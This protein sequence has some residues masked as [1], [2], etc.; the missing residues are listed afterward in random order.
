MKL[1]FGLYR[2]QL[3]TDHFRF[4]RQC[5]ATHVVVHYTDYF[6][7]G[8][9]SGNARGD[10][11]TGD[12]LGWG[13]AGD[14]EKLWTAD[15]LTTLRKN[16]E[17]E[18]LKLWALENFDPAH[19]HDILLD[20]PLRAKHIENVKT[21]IHN[22]GAAGIPVMGYFF[23]IAGVFGRQKGHWAR[24]GA[25]CVGL[26]GYIDESPMPEGMAWN[27]RL[28]DTLGPGTIAPISHDELWRR[29]KAF[30][31]EV[32]PVAERSGVRM[33]AHPDDPP[34]PTVRGTP[35]LVYQ[36]SMYDKMLATV[37]SRANA[38]EYCLGTLTEMTERGENCSAI[39]DAVD[40]HSKQGAL[41]YVHFRN[42]RGVVPNYKETFIDDGDL[43][44]ARVLTI[45]HRNKYDGVL[46]PDHT[47]L[48]SCA[49][50]W[51]SGMAY[52]MGYMKSLMDRLDRGL[53]IW[54][55]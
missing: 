1:G 50:P 51:H 2:H 32:F 19:W 15:E 47:P 11:P 52:A 42:V 44:M 43:D 27:M 45:L 34:L 17:A 13:R 36:P 25:E 30:A 23:S 8:D 33:A 54:R 24:G 20:G 21:I 7:Q 40:R 6:R 53:E 3:D 31:E 18:G 26:D 38:L 4:A 41:G 55:E 49:A 16:I 14:P 28:R 35:R 46:I 22:L 29:W 48:L 5:G 10:Q 12:K 37:P 9:Q 39:Y